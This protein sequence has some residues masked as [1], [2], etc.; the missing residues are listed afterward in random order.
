MTD[1]MLQWGR[2]PKEAERELARR[3][4][5]REAALQWG[6]L[7]KEA[8]SRIALRVA[9]VGLLLQWGRLPK[10]AERR[11]ARWVQCR[12]ACFNGAASRRRRRAKGQA[13]DTDAQALQWGRLPKEA[14]RNRIGAICRPS[15]KLQ[16]GRL[17]KE[18]ESSARSRRWPARC[19][20]NGAASRRRRRGAHRLRHD[21]CVPRTAS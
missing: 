21:V 1:A 3:V 4:V 2:L 16:W 7:P 8:E 13:L 14:E 12:S 20:F 19:C 11:W 17:P 10:E 15:T 6:R 5:E 18:A 9:G